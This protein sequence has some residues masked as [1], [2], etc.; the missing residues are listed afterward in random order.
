MRVKFN[1]RSNREVRGICEYYSRE[2]GAKFAQEFLNE[3]QKTIDR[4]TLWPKSYPMIGDNIYR[5]PLSKYP[6]VII[7]QIEA[8][9]EIRILAVRHHKQKT[10]LG[11]VS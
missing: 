9:E 1:S 11:L 10:D 4:F 6:F 7:Y 8:E 2:A 5:A 3:L